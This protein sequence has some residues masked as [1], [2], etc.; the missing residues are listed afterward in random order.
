METFPNLMEEERKK[1]VDFPA[2]GLLEE[3]KAGGGR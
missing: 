2:W 1:N 3:K